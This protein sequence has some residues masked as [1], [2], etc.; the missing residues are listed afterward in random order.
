MITASSPSTVVPKTIPISQLYQLQSE[1][2]KSK[3]KQKKGANEINQRAEKGKTKIEL[4]TMLD[5]Q[6][7]FLA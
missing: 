6:L 7:L 3:N 5:A 4:A 1:K 2:K